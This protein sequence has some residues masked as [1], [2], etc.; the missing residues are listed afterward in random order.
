MRNGCGITENGHLSNKS[1]HSNFKWKMY[2]LHFL[3]LGL[4]WSK[5]PQGLFFF[6]PWAEQTGSKRLLVLNREGCLGQQ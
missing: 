2:Q 3:I 5:P 6:Q 4:G 1:H